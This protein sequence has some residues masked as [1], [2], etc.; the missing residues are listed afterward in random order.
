[1]PAD[2]GKALWS[3]RRI[4]GYRNVK[5]DLSGVKILYQKVLI[6]PLNTAGK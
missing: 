4:A 6:K 5:G 3:K 2:V 1:L